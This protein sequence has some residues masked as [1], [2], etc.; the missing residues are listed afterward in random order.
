MMILYNKQRGIVAQLLSQSQA[1]AQ[2]IFLIHNL[3]TKIPDSVGQSNLSHL[4]AIIFVRPTEKNIKEII[5]HLQAPKHKSYHI[6]F[7]NQLEEPSLSRLAQADK[8][9]VVQQI[10]VMII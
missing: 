7:S 10:Q 3:G 2:D 6:F 1:L 4:A 8:S 9:E 5:Q